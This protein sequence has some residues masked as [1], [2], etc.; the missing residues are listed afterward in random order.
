MSTV[1]GDGANEGLWLGRADSV[2]HGYICTLQT[3]TQFSTNIR[4]P[5]KHIVH[6]SQG[7]KY[8]YS[9]TACR[10]L[11]GFGLDWSQ[12]RSSMT[13]VIQTNSCDTGSSTV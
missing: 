11:H 7:I 10:C 12:V 6:V 4:L 2:L 9:W 3:A 5:Y 13:C 8:L 1:R